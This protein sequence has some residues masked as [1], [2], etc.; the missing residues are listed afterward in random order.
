MSRDNNK[1]T[2]RA[3]KFKFQRSLDEN[4]IK[5]QTLVAFLIRYLACKL[6]ERHRLLIGYFS[7]LSHLTNHINILISTPQIIIL[8][9]DLTRKE[10]S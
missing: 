1:N 2:V 8:K 5:L 9:L 10:V 7:N 3:F 6:G 4:K